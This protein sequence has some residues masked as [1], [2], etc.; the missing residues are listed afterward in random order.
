[1][2][3]QRKINLAVFQQTPAMQHANQVHHQQ[4][5][6]TLAIGI[7]T[8][9]TKIPRAHTPKRPVIHDAKK[10]LTPNVIILTTSARHVQEEPLIAFTLWITAKFSSNWASV[11]R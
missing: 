3:H 4:R 10:C 9:A 2:I 11:R 1:M 5:I 8:P 7:I 6:N